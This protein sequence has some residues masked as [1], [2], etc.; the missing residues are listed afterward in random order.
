[1][2]IDAGQ[3]PQPPRTAAADV[4]PQRNAQDCNHRR[5]GPPVGRRSFWRLTPGRARN[6]NCNPIFF[7]GKVEKAYFFLKNIGLQFGLRALPGVN[8]QKDLRP[9]SGPERLWLQSCAFRW[10]RTSAAA[11]LGG[12]L[13]QH[14][15]GC[16]PARFAR[17]GRL[18]LQSCAL[19]SERPDRAS[20]FLI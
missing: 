7:K 16:S 5:S 3:S 1:L 9:T 10:G 15:C 19:R 8:L 18:W 14:V 20:R 12:S 13:G 11:V 2:E 17:A 6:P 4:L